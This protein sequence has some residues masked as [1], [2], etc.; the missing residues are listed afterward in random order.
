MEHATINAVFQISDA[1]RE[2]LKGSEVPTETR[3]HI[4]SGNKTNLM[5]VMSSVFNEPTR[6]NNKS[7]SMHL[8]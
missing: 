5:A 6:G 3:I 7:A 4:Q 2:S 1:M 8:L